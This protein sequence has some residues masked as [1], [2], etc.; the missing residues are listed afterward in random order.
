MYV[1]IY[2]WFLKFENNFYGFHFYFLQMTYLNEWVL[3][4]KT[5]FQGLHD[6]S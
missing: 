2:I 5:L 1:C 3:L 6:M 4:D